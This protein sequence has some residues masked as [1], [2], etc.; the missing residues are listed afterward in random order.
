MN[1]LDWTGPEFLRFYIPYGLCIIALAWLARALLLRSTASVPGAHWAPGI[2]PREADAPAIALLRGGP[3]EAVRTLMGRLVS[4]GVAEVTDRQVRGLPEAAA[5]PLQPVEQAAWRALGQAALPAAE[6][7]SRV[8]AA[9]SP[10]LEETSRQLAEQGL[11]IAPG[12]KSVLRG[13][14]AA[15]WLA[16]AGLGLVKLAVALSRGR[17]N[18]GFLALLLIGF[19]LLI[20]L[21]LRLPR[22]LPAGDRY[23]RWLQE[24]HSGLVKRIES[25]QR[26]DAGD[27][28]LA[29]G[30]YGLSAVPLLVPLGL[31]F[32][33]FR[34]R[35]QGDSGGGDSGFL[36]SDSSSDG[37]GDSGG[38][39]SG[40]GGGGGCGGCGGGGS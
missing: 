10:H 14:R 35:S 38:G 34:N 20:F 9:V 30:I 6:A 36:S 5:A 17:T 11:L 33:P 2:Y 23:L 16:V 32:D 28:T 29:A 19:T 22:R 7:E 13:L 3:R 8:Q 18:V 15:A 1:P 31:A 4:L 27:L 37:G 40:C 24:S 21:L 25:G 39:D 26:D 12:Q